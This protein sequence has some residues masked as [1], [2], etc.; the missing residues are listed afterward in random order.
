MVDKSHA[1]NTVWQLRADAWCRLEEAAERLSWPTASA[2]TKEQYAAVVSDLLGQLTPLEPYWA[3]PG[4][5][6]FARM[7]RLFA[8]GQYDKFSRTVSRINRALTT[9]SYRSGD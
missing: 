3:F 4:A 8:G 9:D 7:Q 6:Q 5:P 2:Q 1:Y